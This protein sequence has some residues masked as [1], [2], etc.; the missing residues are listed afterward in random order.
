MNKWILAFLLPLSLWSAPVPP[1]ATQTEV[2]AGVNSFKYVT[3]KTLNNSANTNLHPSSSSGGGT[4]FPNVNLLVGNTNLELSA[5]VRKSFRQ[6]TNGNNIVNLSLAVPASGY[7]VTI[8]HTN[9]AATNYEVT[10]FTNSVAATFYSL[11]DKTNVSIWTVPAGS[12]VSQKFI[13]F[14]GQWIRTDVEQP[15]FTLL[16]GYKTRLST[17]GLTLTV[18]VTQALTNYADGNIGIIAATDV[19]ANFTNVVAGNRSITITTPVIGTSGSLGLVSDGTARTLSV[20]CASAAITW[21]STNDTI[22]LTNLLTNPGKRYLWV[23]RVGMGTDGVSTNIHCW[24]KS[25]TP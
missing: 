19:T 9:T 17:N 15:L 2:D 11:L 1:P 8:T 5:G 3:P 21:L 18:E 10:F 12:V 22:N 13:F 24:G 4:N 7:E 25:Q 23:Y 16:S 20:I 14:S 6:S